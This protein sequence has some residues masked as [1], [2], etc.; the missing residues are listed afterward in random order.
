VEIC[1]YNKDKK[2]FPQLRVNNKKIKN[3]NGRALRSG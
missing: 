1:Y 2:D 3:H